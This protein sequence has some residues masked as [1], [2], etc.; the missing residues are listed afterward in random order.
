MY[1]KQECFNTPLRTE[2]K[3][4][5]PEYCHL[6]LTDIVLLVLEETQSQLT[7]RTCSESVLKIL[8]LHF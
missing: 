5:E 6:F 1:K 3:N 4:Q 7:T 2:K 8:I